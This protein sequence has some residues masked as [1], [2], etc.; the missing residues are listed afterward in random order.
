MATIHGSKAT[1]FFY[2]KDVDTGTFEDA[3]EGTQVVDWMT[4]SIALA[5]APF[6]SGKMKLWSEHPAQLRL[7][8]TQSG[9]HCLHTMLQSTKGHINAVGA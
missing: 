3:L 6:V 1:L 2:V 4:L 5:A 7:I 9:S 8:N